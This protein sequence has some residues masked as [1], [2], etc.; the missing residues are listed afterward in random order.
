[1][2]KTEKTVPKSR[3]L[4]KLF[5]STLYISAFT[6]GGGFVIITLMKKKF[7]DELH[8]IEEDEMLDLT[9]IAQSSPGAIAVN[10][11][12]LVGYRIAGGV[13]MLVAILGTII[14]PMVILSTIS[15]FYTAF[16][17]NQIV[18]L[19]LA[20]MQAGVAAVIME[21]VYT[22]GRN[23]LKEKSI[24]AV[25]IMVGAFVAVRFLGINIIYVILTAGV[26]GA[27]KTLVFDKKKGAKA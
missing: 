12:I 15:V 26:I 22:L 19:L 2:E 18:A 24:L 8:W 27:V 9:A 10:A 14:P 7:V 21:V 4:L 13:G 3:L 25:L 23:V 11:A 16:R 6:F 20:G 1:M 5:I 17:D